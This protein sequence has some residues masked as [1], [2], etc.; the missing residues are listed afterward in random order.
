MAPAQSFFLGSHRLWI[1]GVI[2]FLL[3]INWLF[4]Q[5]N[6][7]SGYIISHQKD[8]VR[9]LISFDPSKIR[10]ATV[11]YKSGTGNQAEIFD[12]AAISGF[13]FEQPDRYFESF[14]LPSASDSA[15]V[16]AELLFR[17]RANLYTYNESFY[18]QKDNVT[19]IIEGE[20]ARETNQD[21]GRYVYM[22]KTYIGTLNRYFSDCLPDKLL[23]G[24]VAYGHKD[25]VD[26]FRKYSQCSGTPFHQYNKVQRSRKVWFHVLAGINRSSI[27][28]E[29]DDLSTFKP[30]NNFF[31]G[32]GVTVPLK[33]LGDHAML[34]AE[35]TYHHHRYTAKMPGFTPTG[36]VQKDYI[37]TLSTIKL[38]IGL[39]VIFSRKDFSPYARAGL[40]GQFP[41]KNTWTIE[42]AGSEEKRFN[43]SEKTAPLI[44]WGAFGF[45]QN[46]GGRKKI[47]VEFRMEKLNDYIDFHGPS[48]PTGIPSSVSNKMV[49][50]GLGF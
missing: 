12:P 20:K 15:R 10:I 50:L 38:P 37:I 39:K 43:I 45:Q 27:K 49:L 41:L 13:G 28:F 40:S 9:G 29:K 23:R 33:F 34:T 19:E 3:A 22:H 5:Q 16:F 44:Y 14:E 26:V 17:G 7:Q 18:I 4:A 47:F 8:T 2:F 25:F 42:F 1:C 11:E 21:G 48:G 6:F 24:E 46:L 30:D 36:T 31:V 35:P 32:A